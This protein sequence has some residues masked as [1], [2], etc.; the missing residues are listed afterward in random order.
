VHQIYFQVRI[1]Q[2]KI[3][4]IFLL[5]FQSELKVRYF[6]RESDHNGKNGCYLLIPFA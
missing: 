5:V 3:H 4:I 1:K 6:I 2:L